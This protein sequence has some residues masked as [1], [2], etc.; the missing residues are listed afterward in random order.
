MT[1]KLNYTGTEMRSSHDFSTLTEVKPS[2]PIL[3]CCV[4]IPMIAMIR[5]VIPER[6]RKW[7][8]T[9]SSNILEVDENL[10]DFFNALKVSDKKW[11]L[12]EN[13]NTRD[14]YAFMVANKETMRNIQRYPGTPS[15]PI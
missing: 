6:L 14:K 13:E 5:A 3:F 2:T 9:I 7:G 11:F 15:K 8:F 1:N 10:P 4:I 12:R